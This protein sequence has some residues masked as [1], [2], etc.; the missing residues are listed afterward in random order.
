MMELLA[1]II[2]VGGLL[3]IAGLL[4]FFCWKA[5]Q[6]MEAE[7]AQAKLRASTAAAMRYDRHL[8]RLKRSNMRAK[9]RRAHTW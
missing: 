4:I 2:V 1:W 9:Y 5:V 3:M 7:A 8:E 6:M